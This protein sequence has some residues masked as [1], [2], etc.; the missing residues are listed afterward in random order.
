M[1]TL[2]T[3][4]DLAY[5][6][7]LAVGFIF[8]VSAATKLKHAKSVVGNVHA[9]EL[10]PEVAE[11]VV[12]WGLVGAELYVA[13]ALLTGWTQWDARFLAL[14]KEAETKAGV[15]FTRVILGGW[16]AGCGAIRQ[17]L[18]SPEA[19]PRIS[20]V[21]KRITPSAGSTGT[22]TSARK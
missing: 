20:G 21:V 10:V 22:R 2:G 7:Q 5:S 9:Y 3:A 19:Y 14:L 13:F 6:S 12:A 4:H 15:R 16:S 11:P 1:S 17:I 18:R 8:L